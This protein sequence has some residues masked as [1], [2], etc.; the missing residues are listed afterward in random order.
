MSKRKDLNQNY[1]AWAE[2]NERTGEV[3]IY[4][5]GSSPHQLQLNKGEKVDIFKTEWTSGIF[6]G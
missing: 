5:K 3:Y 6:Y 1:F 4:N 2:A